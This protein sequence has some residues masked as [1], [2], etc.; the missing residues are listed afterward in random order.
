MQTVCVLRT[1]ILVVL[2]FVVG[3]INLSG[4][5]PLWVFPCLLLQLLSVVEWLAN[6]DLVPSRRVANIFEI[7]PGDTLQVANML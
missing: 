2:F 6:R 7:I 5:P 1:S 4:E 3:G